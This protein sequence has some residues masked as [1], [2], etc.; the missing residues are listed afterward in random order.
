[1]NRTAN[2]IACLCVFAMAGDRIVAQTPN[3]EQTQEANFKAYINLMRA[4]YKKDKV[5]IITQLMALSPEEASKFWPVYNEYD[6]SLTKLGDERIA[7]IRMYSDNYSS[8]SKEMITKIALGMMDVDAKRL[9]LRK[10]YFLRFSQALT[11]KHAARWLQV[12]GQIEK[13]MD[14]QILASL[15]LVE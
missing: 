15:P 5:S 9:D 14:L 8:M 12:E 6:Q 3:P 11:S 4:D 1:M 10:Q 2:Y 7:F 13:L